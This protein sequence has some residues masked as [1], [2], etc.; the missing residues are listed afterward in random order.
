MVLMILCY[1]TVLMLS[2]YVKGLCEAF[3]ATTT[4][5]QLLYTIKAAVSVAVSFA[6]AGFANNLSSRKLLGIGVVSYSL[7]F[8]LISISNSL[9]FY[10]IGAVFFGIGVVLMGSAVIQ[11]VVTRWHRNFLGLKIGLMTVAYSIFGAAFS[12][13]FTKLQLSLGTQTTILIH[14]L[15]ILIPGIFCILFLISD[16]PEKYGLSLEEVIPN[17]ALQEKETI[18]EPSNV[19]AR[20]YFRYPET[21]LLLVGLFLD[22][23][24]Y[25]G[26]LSNASIVYSSLSFDTMQIASLISVQ[27]IFVSVW[28]FAFGFIS[29]R[30]GACRSTVGVSAVVLFT[31]LFSLFNSLGDLSYITTAI[32]AALV[33]SVCYQSMAGGLVFAELFGDKSVAMLMAVSMGF[34][35]CGQMIGTPFATLLYEHTGG[36]A[37]FF[38]IMS[39]ISALIMVMYILMVRINKKR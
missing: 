39:L 12:V 5:I 22:S 38:R 15:V 18:A 27:T 17:E 13:L 23:I 8:F 34:V 16:D 21:W 28:G 10:Y 24:L 37:A 7:F 30:I 2:I 19:S 33:G 11:P 36:Y 14:G 32:Q 6:V 9:V 3:H 20:D 4:Q 31:M 25:G 35:Y 26:Y 29:D 1:G